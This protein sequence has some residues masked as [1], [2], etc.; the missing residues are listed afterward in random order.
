MSHLPPKR[1]PNININNHIYNNYNYYG[2]PQMYPKSPMYYQPCP[3]QF[4][5]N[6][7]Y[8]PQSNFGH[9]GQFGQ[10][11]FGPKFAGNANGGFGGWGNQQFVP[12]GYQRFGGF[13][14]YPA[15]RNPSQFD[16]S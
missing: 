6:Q 12:N 13:N 10:Q 3:P 15:N 8:M 16:K 4:V 14:G 1:V 9:S 5:P 2:M 11:G 7:M